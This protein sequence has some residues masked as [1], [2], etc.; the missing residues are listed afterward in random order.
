MD[1]AAQRPEFIID[2]EAPT[3]AQEILREL[4]QAIATDPELLG[5][6]FLVEVAERNPFNA[7]KT[8]EE[9]ATFI[10]ATSDPDSIQAV[11]E[12]WQ[13]YEDEEL[14]RYLHGFDTDTEALISQNDIYR[15]LVSSLRRPDVRNK[16]L[17]RERIRSVRVAMYVSHVIDLRAPH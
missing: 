11:L 12:L 2:P 3:E 1:A 14:W 6:A 17:I 13:R 15:N 5:D 9:L 7:S 8:T 10:K 4:E 16:E